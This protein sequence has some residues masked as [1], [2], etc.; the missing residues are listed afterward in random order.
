MLDKNTS[1]LIYIANAGTLEGAFEKQKNGKHWDIGLGLA[2]GSNQSKEFGK[3]E[4]IAY[5]HYTINGTRDSSVYKINPGLSF[6]Q[7][8]F[9]YSRMWKLKK[10]QRDI[11]LGARLYNQFTYTAIGADTWFLNQLSIMPVAKT[12]IYEYYKASLNAEVAIPVFSHMVKPPYAYDPSLPE[13]SYF[14]AYLK[15]GASFMSINKFQQ[16]RLRL[17]LRYQLN[18]KKALEVSY[19]FYWMNISNINKENFKAYSNTIAAVYKF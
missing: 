5:D 13:N 11:D 17:N 10:A 2:I 16:L 18:E 15:T 8:S 7:A 6:L 14:K 3:R 1:P 19:R 4:A 9:Q 12:K